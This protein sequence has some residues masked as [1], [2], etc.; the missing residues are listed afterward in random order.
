MSEEHD[1]NDDQNYVRYS[2]NNSGGHWWLKD[3]DWYAL[4]AAGWK[5]EWEKDRKDSRF[6]SMLKDGRWLGALATKAVRRGLTLQEAA[7]EFERIT[8]QSLSEEGCNCCGEPHDLT[9]YT[10]DNKYVRSVEIM[11]NNSWSVTE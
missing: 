1:T 7:D 2:S 5:V 8:G 9:E 4:E 6:S 3:H 10:S 11:R